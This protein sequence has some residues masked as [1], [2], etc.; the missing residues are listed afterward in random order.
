MCKSSR[1]EILIVVNCNE[2][3]IF[4]TNFRKVLTIKFHENSSCGS[5]VFL[6]GKTDGRTDRQADRQTERQTFM[7]YV[8]FAFRDFE[9]VFQKE[10][11]NIK[12]KILKGNH[13]LENQTWLL[14][15]PQKLL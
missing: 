10:N 4:A 8:I 3:R 6:L 1:K 11:V 7:T 15:P 9:N 2:N 13:F 12:T 5:R 14:Y